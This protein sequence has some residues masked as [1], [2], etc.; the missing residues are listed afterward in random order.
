MP[1]PLLLFQIGRTDLQRLRLERKSLLLQILTPSFLDLSKSAGQVS[2]REES[3]LAHSFGFDQDVEAAVSVLSQE[4]G[5]IRN[6]VFADLL[7]LFGQKFE[8]LS[9]AVA[10]VKQQETVEIVTFLV[11]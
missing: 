11:A 1:D 3:G 4:G 7:C 9:V 8:S 10:R 5:L 2:L 6:V